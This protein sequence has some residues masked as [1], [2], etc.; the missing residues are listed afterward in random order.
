[1]HVLSSGANEAMM[2][3]VALNERDVLL[4][5]HGAHLQLLY[6]IVMQFQVPVV[7][8]EEGRSEGQDKQCVDCQGYSSDVPVPS[9]HACQTHGIPPSR[10][11]KY[12][13]QSVLHA[14]VLQDQ[15]I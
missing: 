2:H 4:S 15:L 8:P 14:P 5:K 11:Q 13:S 7:L 9:A 6:N 3:S 10:C 12:T 1:M